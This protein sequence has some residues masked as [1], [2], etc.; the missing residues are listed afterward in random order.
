[1]EVERE[2]GEGGVLGRRERERRGQG[3]GKGGGLVKRLT[4]IMGL[5][6]GQ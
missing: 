6:Y 4:T 3:R 1:M 5:T 2:R